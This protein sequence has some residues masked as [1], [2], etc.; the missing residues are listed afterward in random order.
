MNRKRYAHL[1]FLFIATLLR[2]RF[3]HCAPYCKP[4]IESGRW[5]SHMPSRMLI[6]TLAGIFASIAGL[7]Q[8]DTGSI[9]GTVLDQ[10]GAVIP[11]AS[12][13]VENQNTGA[14]RNAKAN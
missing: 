7:A 11:N 10:T 9:V 5:R 4:M 13:V 14:T 12:L 2:L 8:L 6:L 3:V 1:Y